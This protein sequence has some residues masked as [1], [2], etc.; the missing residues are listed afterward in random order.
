MLEF[1]LIVFL[2]IFGVGT[3]LVVPTLM[4]RRA[5]KRVILIFRRHEALSETGAKTAPEL[6]LGPRR[7]VDRLM[8]L[9]DYK[10][11]ALSV[12]MEARV[13]IQTEEGKL[14]M[15][16]EQLQASGLPTP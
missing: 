7:M 3:I 4:T 2:M 13:V 11:R 16:E 9:R 8:R 14:F 6:G 10:P 5:L 12:L 15:S 1:L